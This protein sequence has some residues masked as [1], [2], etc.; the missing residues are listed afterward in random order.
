MLYDTRGW[1]QAGVDFLDPAVAALEAANRR[2]TSGRIEHLTL[3]HLLTC[4][5]LLAFRLAHHAQA[6]ARLERSLDILRPLNESRVLVEALTFLG[7]VAEATGNYARAVDLYSEGQTVATAIGD[8]WF[9]ALCFI[10]LADQVG[11]VQGIMKP[12][13]I[14]AQI[15]LAVVEWRTIG[16]LRLIAAGLG[17]LGWS[18]LALGRY[19]EARAALEEG[20]AL[21]ISIG[22]RWLLGLAYRGLGSVAQAQGEHAQALELFDESL[23]ILKELGVRQDVARVLAEA[24]RS[25][26]ALGNDAEAERSWRES[27]RL[28]TETQGIFIALEAL[29]GLAVLRAKHGDPE[30]A[31]GLLLIVLGHPSSTQGTKDRAEHL[32]WEFESQLTSQ[33]VQVAQAWARQQSFDQVVNQVL[34]DFPLDLPVAGRNRSAAIPRDG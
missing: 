31:L 28:A 1:F 30:H 19:A 20:I 8:R 2:A 26:F 11:I 22:D 13:D 4:Q 3:G 15:R 10:C 25:V 34:G 24:S 23:D 16:D 7:F 18:A 12:E 14:Y 9:A 32:R 6:Q 27:L 21:S 29:V 17:L 5:A 33:Q